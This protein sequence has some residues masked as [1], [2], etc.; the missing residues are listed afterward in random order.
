LRWWL[1]WLQEQLLRS[2]SHLLR[3]GPDLLRSRHLRRSGDLCRSRGEL[4][5]FRLQIELLQIALPPQLAL[6]PLEVLQQVELLRSGPELLRSGS[7]LLCSRC[8]DVRRPD[9]RCSD[10]FRLQLM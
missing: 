7:E 4:L 2:R 3:P 1:R 9:L 6:R 8:P 10:G 5:Q